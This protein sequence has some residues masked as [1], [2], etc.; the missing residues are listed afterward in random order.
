MGPKPDLK[1]WGSILARLDEGISFRQ[2]GEEFGISRQRVHQLARKSRPGYVRP[3]IPYS[4]AA[5]AK[6]TAGVRWEQ[7][8]QIIAEFG[9]KCCRCGFADPRALQ[10]DH[11]NG[12]GRRE[13]LEKTLNPVHRHRDIRENPGKYQLLCSNCNW[14]KRYENGEDARR[15]YVALHAA[16]PGLRIDMPRRKRGRPRKSEAVGTN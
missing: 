5:Y 7:R 1:R 8:L 3:R 4:P 16:P 15:E 6:K 11:I 10:F 12:G 2:V 14:I 13:R 9:G